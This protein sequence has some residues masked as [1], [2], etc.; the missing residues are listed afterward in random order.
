MNKLKIILIAVL[1]SP[2]FLYFINKPVD[3][4]KVYELR[5]YHAHPG[6]LEDLQRRFRKHTTR[7]FEKHGMTNVG[8]WIPLENLDNKLIYILSYP[9]REARENSWKAFGSDPEWQKVKSLSEANGKLVDKV[10]S[11]F[12]KTTDF[13]PVIA[14]DSSKDPRVFELRTYITPS[15]R[16]N[17]LL[18]RFRDYTMKLFSKHGMTNVGYW[19]PVEKEQGSENKLIY[20][21]AHKSKEAGLKSWKAFGSDPEWQKVVK[22]SEANGRLAESIES[23]YMTPT[24]YSPIK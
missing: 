13:S 7:I 24:D 6:K 12:L 14:P 15:G 20:I 5:V 23:V 19:V 22:A 17:D 21:L 2:L 11:S 3:D 9:S 8:Y 4:G 1:L 18:T 16:L 10:E